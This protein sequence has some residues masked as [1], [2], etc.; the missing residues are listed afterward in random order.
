MP[1]QSYETTVF[2]VASDL[3]AHVAVLPGR[4]FDETVETDDPLVAAAA[5]ELGDPDVAPFG[6]IE[7]APALATALYAVRDREGAISLLDSSG[8]TAAGSLLR[9]SAELITLEPDVV[10]FAE[11]LAYVAQIPFESSQLSGKAQAAVVTSGVILG[12]AAAAHPIV[13]L[14]TGAAILIIRVTTGDEI[15]VDP[16][17]LR[18][19][20]TKLRRKG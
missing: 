18:S 6:A 1:L 2:D 12:I 7:L 8:G 20:W 3:A 5:L 14:T 16:G 4:S 13:L 17:G 10:R 19:A 11:D 15:H 9:V